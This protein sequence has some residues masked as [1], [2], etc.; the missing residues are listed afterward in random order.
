MKQRL[1]VLLICGWIASGVLWAQSAWYSYPNNSSISIPSSG[2]VGIGTPSPGALLHLEANAGAPYVWEKYTAG[3]TMITQL[4]R[5]GNGT[6]VQS[7]GNIIL[8]PGTSGSGN[9]GIGTTSP[10]QLLDVHGTIAAQEVIVTQ[11]GADYVFGPDYGLPSLA[12][13]AAYIAD[14]HHLPDIPSADEM[15]EKGVGVADMQAKLLAK[16]E[17]ITL[18]MIQA[19]KENR[20]LRDRIARLE[21]TTGGKEAQ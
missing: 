16:I 18:H 9:V 4:Q 12:E 5:T 13:V 11:S 3:G 20:E 6:E 19:E 14:H 1:V 21:A 15:K 17:E 8:T 2:N 10:A 7:Y